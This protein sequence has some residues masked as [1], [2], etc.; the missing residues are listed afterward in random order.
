MIRHSSRERLQPQLP[1]PPDANTIL[2]TDMGNAR[3]FAVHHQS[4]IRFVQPWG[5][6]AWD[7]RRWK[8]DDTGSAMRLARA[9]VQDLLH[10]AHILNNRADQLLEEVEQ[11]VAAQNLIAAELAQRELVAMQRQAKNMVDWA[12]KSQS[13][14]R[15]E[16]LLA[17]A[18]SEPELAAQVGDFDQSP[19]LLNV[20]NGTLD[21]RTG[22]L[23]PHDP[24][25][26]LTKLLRANY[27]PAAQCP[28]WL[29][30]LERV[31]PDRTVR[32]FLQRSIGYSLTGLVSEQVFWFL[33]GTGANGKSVFSSTIVTL[34]GDYAMKVRAETLMRKSGDSIPEEVAAMAGRRFALASE[35]GEGQHLNESLIKDLTGGDRMRARFLHRNSFE[36]DPQAKIWMFGN[37]KPLVTGTD[38]GIWRRPR[39]VPFSVVIPE[40]ERDPDLFA[41]LL[42]EMDGIL[43]WAVQ[44]CRDW[45]EYGL[46]APPAV[47]AATQEFRTEN[48]LVGRFLAECTQPGGTTTAHALYQV[49]RAWSE[50]EGHKPMSNTA[51]GRRLSERCLPRV[52]SM[53][54]HH[55][56]GISLTR[57]AD[58]LF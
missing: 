20:L 6:V 22:E 39:L 8:Q 31:Q 13:R 55:Y 53:R 35:L 50:S 37:H 49:Y 46:E 45:Q 2:Q 38:V 43:T 41:K 56:Q 58:D 4:A 26:M 25:H 40:D 29:A 32:T 27:H 5:W 44:G 23:Q 9:T 17:L 33:Y 36:Y 30:F 51:L 10:E 11:A 42:Q 28:V 19:W 52:R 18:K 57:T 16:S 24:T 21:L 3:R 12:L 54:G 15:L 14:S 7:K 47:T 34:L 1:L 48:D